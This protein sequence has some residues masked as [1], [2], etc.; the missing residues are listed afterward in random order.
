MAAN[1]AADAAAKLLDGGYLR[2]LDGRRR[3][4]AELRFGV[5]AFTS[6]KGGEAT[7]S[8]APTYQAAAT[9]IAETFEAAT[10]A[11]DVVLR[12]FVGADLVLDNQFIEAGATVTIGSFTYGE[13]L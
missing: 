5:P 13:S 9:G 6:A 4:L 10:F 3:V 7:A 2:L 8:L 1:A 12:G 11:G